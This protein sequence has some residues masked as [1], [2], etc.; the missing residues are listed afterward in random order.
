MNNQ[1]SKIAKKTL[2]LLKVYDWESISIDI[3][4]NKL[5]LKKKKISNNIKNKNDLF[6]NINQYFDDI[7]IDK[8]QSIEKSTSRDMIF[9]MF[10]LRFDIL[11]QY[12]FS[13]L[14]IF[15][16]YKYNPKSFILLIPPLIDSIDLMAKSSNI[17][18]KGL[19]GTIKI[20][21]LLIIY[22]S[23]FLTWIKDE[24]PS[25]DKTMNAL[26]NYLDKADNILKL[27]KK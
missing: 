19:I 27:L 8:S 18:T 14:R 26:D 6:K 15:D 12:R 11:S 25:L 2:E 17:E 9:E 5:K 21:G 22:F 23:S 13:I 24:T 4:C 16:F 7:M 20:K 10:M 3:I 1:R